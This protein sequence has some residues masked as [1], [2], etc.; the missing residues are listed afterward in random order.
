[1]VLSSTH[2][3]IRLFLYCTVCTALCVRTD[4]VH[5]ITSCV[6]MQLQSTTVLTAFGGLYAKS[7]DL[8]CLDGEKVVGTLQK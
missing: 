4:H 8:C 3:S 1:M 6:T 5:N 2:F 7:E